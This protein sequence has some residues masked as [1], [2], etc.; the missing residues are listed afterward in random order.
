MVGFQGE[1]Q[2]HLGL[3][4]AIKS[5]FFAPFR[6]FP[7]C[8]GVIRSNFLG[9]LRVNLPASGFALNPL[10]TL[11]VYFCEDVRIHPHKDVVVGLLKDFSLHFA[12][13]GEMDDVC[14]YGKR[15]CTED[16]NQKP[17]PHVSAST[18]K[19]YKF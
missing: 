11:N 6:Q 9:L 18:N 10:N 5:L 4:F 1:S 7:V 16:H 14:L 8:F 3:V 19:P 13:G 15:R 12:A 17:T 2:L